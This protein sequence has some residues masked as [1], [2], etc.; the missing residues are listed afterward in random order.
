MAFLKGLHFV[1]LNA[2]RIWERSRII[3]HPYAVSHVFFK[4][5]P[6]TLPCVLR[7]ILTKLPVCET[8][9]KFSIV[10]PANCLFRAPALRVSH[11]ECI[12]TVCGT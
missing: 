1:Q 4:H 11:L 5:W 8:F 12:N 2:D 10:K 9:L 7:C 6:D 3:C